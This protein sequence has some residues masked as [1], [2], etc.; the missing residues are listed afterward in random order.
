MPMSI[1]V[2]QYVTNTYGTFGFG[3]LNT[4]LFESQED[5]ANAVLQIAKDEY[6]NA[7][8]KVFENIETLKDFFTN[9]S[10][11]DKPVMVFMISEISFKIY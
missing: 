7:N 1:F 2:L 5:A 10:D 11:N 9:L 8:P 4:K 3:D 6:P